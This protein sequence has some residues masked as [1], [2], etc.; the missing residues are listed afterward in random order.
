MGGDGS[1]RLS[2]TKRGLWSLLP[3]AGGLGKL[4]LEFLERFFRPTLEGRRWRKLAQDR[5]SAASG[6]CHRGQMTIFTSLARQE[7]CEMIVNE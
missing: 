2:L 7:K 1:S 6:L 5:D 3:P 4:S